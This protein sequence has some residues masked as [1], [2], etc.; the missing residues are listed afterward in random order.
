MTIGCEM[1]MLSFDP[2]PIVFYI[3]RPFAYFIINEKSGVLFA[4]KM[5]TI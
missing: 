5:H 2:D 1:L 4:G 3:D